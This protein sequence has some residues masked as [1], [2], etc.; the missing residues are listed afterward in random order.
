MPDPLD[1]YFVAFDA[2]LNA[3][4]PSPHAVAP[5]WVAA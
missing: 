3:I 4:V 2:K 5:C 1:D